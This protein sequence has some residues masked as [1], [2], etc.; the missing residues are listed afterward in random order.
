M[1]EYQNIRS[2]SVDPGKFIE[3]TIKK[4]TAQSPF[5]SLKD[6]DGTRIFDEPLVGFS[7][8]DAQIFTG[9]KE[10]I[11]D[12]HLT[13]RE[14]LVQHLR[15]KGIEMKPDRISVISFVMPATAE[16]RLSLHKESKVTSLRWNHTRWQG[17]DFIIETSRCV[18][19]ELEKHGFEA[20]APEIS[21][22]FKI[23]NITLGSNW[24]QRH[25]AYACGLGTFS[26]NDG[27]ITP[28]GIAMRLGSVV[29]DAV[30]ETTPMQYQNF[31]ANCLYYRGISCQRCAQRCPA[32]AIS[33]NGHDK[34][35]CFDYLNRQK[36]LAKEIGRPENYIGRYAGCGL[37]QTNVP[38]EA[39][40]PDPD[41]GKS[42]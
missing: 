40:I 19:K 38:C 20:I 10:I 22:F 36:D 17:Q 12:F 33:G 11:G 6:I 32:G 26:L 18:V 37:C 35:K 9:Y 13:P 30:L 4:F 21:T 1:C 23:Q 29:T 28:K 25:I 3:E 34:Q 27:F 14:V 24:S 15:N 16:T 7:D 31:R 5:N 39:G 8:G 41:F 2:F 42:S